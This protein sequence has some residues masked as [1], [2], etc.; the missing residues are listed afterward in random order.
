MKR[1][2]R[3]AA[4]R[5]CES[6]PCFDAYRGPGV[7]DGARSLALRVRLGAADRTLSEAELSE[8]RAAMIGAATT[9]L[10][11]TLR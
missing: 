3:E 11:A 5:V 7:P 4:G 6:M 2:L 10:S 8:V 9:S 1:V